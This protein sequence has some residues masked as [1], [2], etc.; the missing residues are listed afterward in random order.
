VEYVA[1][2]APSSWPGFDRL[3]LSVG[4]NAV[5]ATGQYVGKD[6]FN[7]FSYGLM[8]G[9]A[10]QVL[11]DKNAIVL[12]EEL[13]MRLFNT[14]EGIIGKAVQF[15]QEREFLVS[16]V[17]KGTP[18]NSS[19][20]FD[21]AL[22]FETFKDIAPWV[23]TW[24]GG[25]SVYV[26][27]KEGTDVDQFNEKIVDLI[28]SR[29]NSGMGR[30]P[31]LVPYSEMYLHGTY[32]NGVQAGG[33]IEYVRLFAVIAVF[34]LAIACINFMNLSTA[35]ASRRLKEVGVK[36]ALGAGRKPL[37]VQYLGESVVMA[38]LSLLVAL[39]LVMLF[40]PQFNTIT[41][42][43]LSLGFDIRL[44]L[45]VLAITLVTGIMAGSYPAL[46]LSG[47]NPA[48]VLKGKLNSSVGEVWSRKGLV[49]F[50][51]V[52]SVLLIV[53]VLVVYKQIEFVQDKNLGYDKDNVVYFDI[54][55]KVDGNVETFLSEMKRIPG[56]VNASSTSHDMVGRGWT[57]TGVQW[58]GKTPDDFTRFQ[59]VGVGL[60]FIET[61]DIEIKE[62]RAFS[63]DF[64]ADDSGIIFNEAAIEAMGLV[65]PLGKS[66][67][68]WEDKE[69]IG[70]VKNFHFE[71]FY[72]EVT[73]LFFALMPN[74]VN[75]IMARI[76]AG[77]ERE[78]LERLQEFYQGYNPGFPFSFQFL[79]QDYQN[80]YVA[81]QRVSV[82]S[83][84]FAGLAILISC[85]GLF[86][87][88]AFTAERRIKEIGIRKVL[89]ASEWKIV[90]L[91]SGH[92][93]VMVLAAIVIALPLSY[94]VTKTWLDGF[95]YK[96]DLE[97]WYFIGAGLLTMLIALLTVSFQS[98]KA[99]LANPVESL[100]TE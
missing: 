94:Y 40:L 39:L 37:I 87:L 2:V 53:S 46:Y 96:I 5:R 61:L 86:G 84:Y 93:A 82:L 99:A 65:N 4:E 15:Q 71:S 92:F 23:L 48:M 29:T 20:Q 68:L 36:K 58:E 80:Q 67:R 17:F 54:E 43:T 74:D 33:R 35:K 1:A 26:V 100:R 30:T 49:V 11:S 34:I 79:D 70:V 50:Q 75:K 47:F 52:L 42:K 66:V 38:G 24:D 81:E 59:V 25:P 55:G 64:G 16:G 41:G 22:S 13:A 18:A 56:I 85:L 76:E 62:G 14:T 57:T 77:R 95:A 27:L 51:F 88:A 97:W 3:T 83:R 98:V 10:D 91:L 78:T 31:F 32:E 12:S 69:I 28:K 89:G 21:F 44:V 90:E 45:S 19:V 60:D 63:R 7:I 9:D 73:P 72:E 6:Y 8:E